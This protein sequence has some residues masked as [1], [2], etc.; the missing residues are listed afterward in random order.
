MA[1]TT[2]W[3]PVANSAIVGLSTILGIV[4]TQMWTAQRDRRTKDLEIA[5]QRQN[6]RNDFQRKTL[7]ALQVSIQK[8]ARAIGAAN[9]SDIAAARQTGTWGHLLGEKLNQATFNTGIRLNQLTDRVL[10]EELRTMIS[11]LKDLDYDALFA[12]S[13]AASEAAMSKWVKHLQQ[14]NDRLGEILRQVL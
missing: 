12:P 2:E 4:V 13:Q 5:A 3:I 14:V 9:L 6:Q 7:L 1:N 8:Y 10:D 11:R